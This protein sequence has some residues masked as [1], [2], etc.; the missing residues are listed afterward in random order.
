MKR[1]L[2]LKLLHEKQ[3]IKKIAG[4]LSVSTRTVANVKK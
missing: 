1:A 3:K 2:I 4:F